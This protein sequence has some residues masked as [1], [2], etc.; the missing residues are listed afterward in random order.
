MEAAGGKGLPLKVDIR[1]EEQVQ[2]AVQKTLDTFGGIDILVNNAGT[3][4]PEQFTKIKKRKS[5]IIGNT[6]SF[7]K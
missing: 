4:I 3:N 5:S 1:E 6:F 7:E 2:N